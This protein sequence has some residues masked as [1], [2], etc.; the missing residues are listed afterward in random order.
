VVALQ[1]G[2]ESLASHA[3]VHSTAVVGFA[4]GLACAL[5]YWRH[6]R[7]PNAILDLRLFRF[8]AFAIATLGGSF[9][10]IVLGAT[11]FLF[12]LYSQY[13]LGA[14]PAIAG[15]LMGVLAFGQIALR[16]GLDPLL[17]RLGIRRLL[18][19]NS[20]SMGLLLAG[21]LLF[22]PGV[23]FWFVG[24]FLFVF[25]LI[26]S[27]QLSTLAGLN[28][29]GLPD[30]ALAGATSLGTVVQR[31]AT[32]FGISLTAILLGFATGGGQPDRHS[33]ILP[34]LVLSATMGLSI[35]SFLA[36]RHGD[37]ADLMRTPR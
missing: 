31:L 23:S 21:L 33:F 36:L 27:I 37:G 18:I 32:A 28:F 29:S 26:H 17:K 30:T 8:R 4:I 1:F 13:A 34:V 11:L 5:A 15:Y 14:S 22:Q 20:A 6:S 19:V 24:T 35:L 25:G 2:L 12:P 7:R 9:S 16:L 10:R 3:A